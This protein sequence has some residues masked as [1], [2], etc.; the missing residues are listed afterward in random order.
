MPDAMSVTA[1]DVMIVDLSGEAVILNKENWVYYGLNGMGYRVWNL[2]QEPKRIEEI[3]NILLREYDVDS[4][5]CEKDL[6]AFICEMESQG[7]VETK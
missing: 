2:I 4:E 1:K 6:R 3:N 5:V 7:L